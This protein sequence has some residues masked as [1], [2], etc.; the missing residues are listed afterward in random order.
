MGHHNVYTLGRLVQL[1][2]AVHISDYTKLYPQKIL[3][4]TRNS[5]ALI[6][7]VYG[8]MRKHAEGFEFGLLNII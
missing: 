5:F 4:F 1:V 7:Y 3:I 2:Q 6:F 8:C